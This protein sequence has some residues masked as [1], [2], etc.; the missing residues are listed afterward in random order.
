MSAPGL[1][2]ARRERGFTLIE[3]LVAVT[4]GLLLTTVIASLFLHSRATYGSTEAL[5][6]MQ[7]NIRYAHQLLTRTIH[8]AGYKSAPNSFTSQIFNAANLAGTGTDGGG[9][10][11]D[12][13]TVR[14]Q[15]SGNGAGTP[16]GS[17]SDCQGRV[18]DAGAMAVNIY[19]IAV[20]A[21]GGNALFCNNGVANLEVVPD[22]ENMKLLFGEDTNA[23]LV[24]DRFVAIGNVTN[25]DNIVAI[26][27]ALL[28]RTANIAAKALP[29]SSTYTLNA[30]V[31]GP[32]ADT[33]IR[34]AVTM[35]V[36]LRNRTP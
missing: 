17:V 22:V 5:S 10:A 28:F 33:R 30:T 26:R 35:T 18:I 20:G 34:R 16:D 29:D 27:V 13:F 6:R 7:E 9:V 14:F 12:S 8:L 4:I 19:T 15:G 36:N 23:D 31:V 3:L 11:P 1:F 32:F 24:A 2:A 21:D 25:L